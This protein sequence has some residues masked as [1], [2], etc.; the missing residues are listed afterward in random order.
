MIKFS[1]LC[2]TRCRFK[3]AHRLLQ[4][5]RESAYNPD[6][7]EVLYAVDADDVKTITEFEQLKKICPT[8]NFSVHI[9]ER[10]DFINGDYYNWLCQFAKGEYLWIAGDDVVVTNKDWDKLVWDKLEEYLKDKP[11]R[12]AYGIISDGT[13]PPQNYA[14]KTFCCFPIV[15]KEA[16]NL[17][18]FVLHGDIPTWGADIVL[19]E[20]YTH[21]RVNRS[22]DLTKEMIVR[23]VSHHTGM[24]KRDVISLNV[25]KVHK[26]YA[27]GRILGEV[28][29]LILPVNINTLAT[30]IEEMKEKLN[31]RMVK[32]QPV[33]LV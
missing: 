8:W 24:A 25:E 15:S 6:E 17:L 11:D 18:G 16:Y 4:S 12:I 33:Q 1:I 2:P 29:N 22:I 14:K 21:E 7:I 3:G 13:P 28:R 31:E 23:H 5:A 19:Y 9:R 20:L 32:K 26:K 10:S 30:Y 27:G